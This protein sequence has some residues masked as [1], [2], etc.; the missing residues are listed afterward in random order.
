MKT[1][2]TPAAKRTR[3]QID[4]DAS[5]SR[6]AHRKGHGHHQKRAKKVAAPVKDEVGATVSSLLALVLVLVLVVVL[7][8]LLMRRGPRSSPH[9]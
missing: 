6:D 5:K 9:L 2:N 8:L 7:L 3:E 1:V 4:R